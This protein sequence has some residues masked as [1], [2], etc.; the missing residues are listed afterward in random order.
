MEHAENFTFH[1]VHPSTSGLGSG[2]GKTPKQTTQNTTNK[3]LRPLDD[4]SD[5]GVNIQ[6][7]QPFPKYITIKNSNFEEEKITNL[8]PFV[9]EKVVEGLIGI[10]KNVKKTQR[11]QLI[12]RNIQK[13]PNG[14]AITPNQILQYKRQSM[15][16]PNT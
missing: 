10:A 2:M 3:R 12:D 7:Q 5:D 4:D 13:K 15:S 1:M 11:Q 14:T 8:S 9:I 6:K 16:T